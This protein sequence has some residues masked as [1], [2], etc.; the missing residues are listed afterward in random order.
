[1]IAFRLAAQGR[2]RAKPRCL[3]AM[4]LNELSRHC[5]GI[6]QNSDSG[7]LGNVDLVEKNDS[8]KLKCIFGDLVA[9][10]RVLLKR[11]YIRI[12]YYSNFIINSADIR[13]LDFSRN[14]S[15]MHK[16]LPSVTR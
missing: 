6:I 15:R 3:I 11:R 14:V 12:F 5:V 16:E 2:V 9:G 1:M 4:F 7:C 8:W 13:F 10:N